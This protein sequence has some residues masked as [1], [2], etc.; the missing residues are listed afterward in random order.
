VRDWPPITEPELL[1]RLA[2]DHE[3]FVDYLRRILEERGAHEYDP[4]VYERAIGYPWQRPTG[5]YILRDEKVELLEDLDPSA[6]RSAVAAFAEN[7]HPVVSFGSNG[8]PSWL[9]TKL[10]HFPDPVDREAVVLTGH[11]HDV[12]VGVAPALSIFGYMPAA[13][14]ASPG[15]AVRAAVLWV[16]PA[17]VTQLTWSELGYWLGRLDEA[18][19]EMDEADVEVEGAFAYIHRVGAFCIDGAPVA[20]AAIPAKNRTAVSM[21]QSQLLDFV[22]GLVIGPR[23]VGEDLVREMFEDAPGV[24]ARAS[25]AIW[26]SAEQLRSRWTSFPAAER[27]G[28][29]L[30]P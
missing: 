11:L 27:L 19:F 16:T 29:G 26:P 20:L 22:A 14:F 10:A 28:V 6:R 8:A 5:S 30:Q 12:D 2:L 1:E 18:R 23:A 24:L 15:T 4:A 9:A 21:S 7:R 13:L 3:G 25:E 17:Q